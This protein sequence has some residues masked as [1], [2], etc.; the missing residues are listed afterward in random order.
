MKRWR[1]IYIRL[2]QLRA[3]VD[4]LERA[5]R[6]GKPFTTGDLKRVLERVEDE[7][8]ALSADAVEFER[9]SPVALARRRGITLAITALIEILVALAITPFE[10]TIAQYA[11]I[12]VFSPLVSAVSGNHGLQTAAAVIR[13]IA[14]GEKKPFWE[15]VLREL[16][17]GVLCGLGVG[18]FSGFVAFLVTGKLLAIPVVCISMMAGMMT[19]GFMGSVFPKIL[20]KLGFDPA[21]AT[22][23]AETSAQDLI[24]YFTFLLVLKLLGPLFP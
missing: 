7:I 20:H 4:E 5:Q 9:S 12:Y 15:V 6:E 8:F 24:S 22:G 11:A 16:I 18:L 17:V 1:D 21:I 13:A 23:P 19:S 3:A 2:R 10:K 14:V